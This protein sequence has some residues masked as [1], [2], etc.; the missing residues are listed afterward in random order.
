MHLLAWNGC[1]GLVVVGCASPSPPP[2]AEAPPP[3]PAGPSAQ[4]VNATVLT[5]GCQDLGARSARLAEAAM[6]QLVEG[7]SSVPG[8]SAQF[9]ATLEPGGR[10]EISTAA[11]QPAVVPTCILKHALV[12]RVKL[13]QPCR[14]DVRIEQTRV[15]LP[16]DGGA[17]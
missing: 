1:F 10:V 4:L 5:N 2:A 14:L 9:T 15:A 7:C 3:E 13:T 11:G 17:G 12:H 6:N 8:G 16:G